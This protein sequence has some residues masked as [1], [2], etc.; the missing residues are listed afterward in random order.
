MAAAALLA[1]GAGCRQNS[2]GPL[3]QAGPEPGPL[4]FTAGDSLTFDAW[5][6]D[7][8]GYAIDSSHTTPVWRVLSLNDS[9]AGATGVTTILVFPSQPGPGQSPDTLRFRFL[10]S[11]D[12]AEFGFIAEALRV[13]GSGTLPPAWDR[14]AAFSLPTNGTWNA[15]T[16]DAA[17]LD[18]LTGTVL[19]DQG[20][21]VAGFNGVRNAFHGYGVELTSQNLDCTI[22][23]SGN[24][25]AMLVIREE[26]AYGTGGRLL[27]MSALVHR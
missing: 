6:I 13:T 27:V 3:A 22:V 8:Y 11:G 23:V 18:S 7:G 17:G 1:W 24:P 20:Y 2:T 25:P 10:P 15:G 9:W 14:I 16:D 5:L 12:I 26:S 19:G 4:A 21:F